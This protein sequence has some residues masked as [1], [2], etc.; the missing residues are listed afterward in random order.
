MLL[1]RCLHIVC[2]GWW[3]WL[4]LLVR[5]IASGFACGDGAYLQ[6]GWWRW[7]DALVVL[8]SFAPWLSA[9]H[10]LGPGSGLWVEHLRLL[11]LLRL[12]RPAEFSRL[13]P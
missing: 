9:A 2:A 13:H 5:S 10:L 7:V 3:W 12:I 4:Q 6:S 11:R 8:A 1:P